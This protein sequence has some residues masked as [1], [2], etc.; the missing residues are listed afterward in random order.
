MERAEE[1]LVAPLATLASTFRS[2]IHTVFALNHVEFA[3]DKLDALLQGAAAAFRNALH[4]WR[5]TYRQVRREYFHWHHLSVDNPEAES[6]ARRFKAQALSHLGYTNKHGTP[7]LRPDA[8]LFYLADLGFLPRYEFPGELLSL[9]CN[10]RGS[11]PNFEVQEDVFKALRDWAPGGLRRI[12]AVGGKYKPQFFRAGT[13]DSLL[14]R[15]VC[16]KHAFVGST[17]TERC[18][19]CGGGEHYPLLQP[20][21][22][23]AS[24]EGAIDDSSEE[25]TRKG[26]QS[27]FSFSRRDEEGKSEVPLGATVPENVQVSRA[28]A[29]ALLYLRQQV[30]LSQVVGTRG[31]DRL[32]GYRWC[33]YCHALR[34]ESQQAEEAQ[35]DLGL[36]TEECQR[37]H[38]GAREVPDVL[39]FA[40]RSN[41]TLVEIHIPGM[42]S[43]LEDAPEGVDVYRSVLEALLQEGKVLCEL[44]PRGEGLAGTI[45]EELGERYLVFY[46]P[47]PG[48]AGTIE[49]LWRQADKWFSGA[50]ARV[51]DRNAQGVGCVCSRACDRCLLDYANQ[52]FHGVLSRHAATKALR[53]LQGPD[54]VFWEKRDGSEVHDPV[55][56]DHSSPLEAYFAKL[57]STQFAVTGTNLQSQR[58]A[59]PNRV[60]PDYK[61][62]TEDRFLFIDS[63]KFH[64][65]DGEDPD[66]DWARFVGDCGKRNEML[67]KGKLWISLTHRMI[68]NQPRSVANVLA[69]LKVPHTALSRAE[70]GTTVALPQGTPLTPS[71]A[72]GLTAWLDRIGREL[73]EN[74]VP[75]GF[76]TKESVLHPDFLQGSPEGILLRS[77]TNKAALSYAV[78]GLWRFDPFFEDNQRLILAGYQVYLLPLDVESESS[79]RTLLAP[80]MARE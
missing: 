71:V 79:L 4:R 39:L 45:G 7:E 41:V 62:R 74:Q 55:Q 16:T 57:V 61:S 11:E 34:Q 51:S 6:L 27:Y 36:H 72:A 77:D 10:G 33:S 65:A 9:H 44:G 48:G 30:D 42:E 5:E 13:D 8:P 59:I 23:E 24:R 25:R 54:G 1:R 3:T 47:V 49:S 50:L 38:Q 12:W 75:L 2:S 56:W 17:E 67:A 58:P 66:E 78:K 60:V 29:S 68:R 26:T 35:P 18:W 19:Q 31:H 70:N 28:G 21:R 40:K 63:R 46:D 37:Q 76:L 22:V 69:W 43:L 20:T 53:L 80:M 32:T 73:T 52:Q 15:Y 64:G 14:H